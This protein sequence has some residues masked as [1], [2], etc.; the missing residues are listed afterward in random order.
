MWEDGKRNNCE[1]ITLLGSSKTNTGDP[2]L[3][4]RY[5]REHYKS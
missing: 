4:E 1:V 3:E 2:I 5:I